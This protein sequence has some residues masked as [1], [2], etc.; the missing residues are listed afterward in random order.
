MQQQS[1]SAHEI[2]L[3]AWLHDRSID[4]LPTAVSPAD[5]AAGY[6]IQDA[7]VAALGEPI[8]GYKIAATSAAG[9]AH[10]AVDQPISG[11]LRASRVL[12]P[13]NAAPMAG[14]TM[15][16]AEAE[17]V[18]EFSV[19][20]PPRATPYQVDEAMALIADLHLGIELPNSR[21]HDFVSVGAAQL[22]A[23][24]ACAYAF[25]LG[26]RVARPWRDLEL[27]AH[28][29]QTLV[30]GEVVSRGV[31]GDALGDPR[32]ALTWFVNHYRER[33]RTL[34][35]GSFVTTGV[36]GKPA[37]IEPGQHVEVDF[38]ELGTLS[39]DLLEA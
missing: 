13:G 19:D 39:V 21:F 16:V 30:D 20:V 7:V 11:Q 26:P 34:A 24:N 29:V 22:V 9:Q 25:I 35:A 15:R 14:N 5:M 18:F 12:A 38:G 33:G 10:I 37:P 8:V 3:D 1:I 2:L 6:A 32:I 31:G 17:F 4:A 27:A 28:P 36:C 23:D